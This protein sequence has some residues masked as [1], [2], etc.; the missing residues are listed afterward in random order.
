VKDGILNDPHKCKFDPTTLLC[1]GNIT[2]SDTSNCLTAAQLETVKAMYAPAKTKSGNI[3]YPGLPLG[4]E[5]G[6]TRLNT[7][8]P[9]AV[10]LGSFKYVLYQDASWD[11]RKFDLDHDVAAADEKAGSTLNAINPDLT[12]FQ[13]HG[14]KLLMYHG[15]SDQLITAENS[16]NYYQSVQQKMV[17]NQSDWYRLFMMPGMMHCR[18]GAGPDQFSMMGIIERWRETNTPPDQI[19]AWHVTQNRV[20]MTRPLCPYPQVAVYKGSGNP[21]DAGNFVCRVQ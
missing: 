1:K 17:G 5:L 20:D 13:K 11:W 12:A 16:I 9:M 14:G 7:P 6:W 3:V 15:W 19:T 10:P 8:E 4:G 21:N 18:G 2:P